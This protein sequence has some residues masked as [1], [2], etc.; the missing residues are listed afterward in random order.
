M[1]RETT[2]AT[3]AGLAAT[4]TRAEINTAAMKR[5]NGRVRSVLAALGS[6]FHMY[7][8]GIGYKDVSGRVCL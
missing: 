3:A 6:C 4:K 2:A 5:P 1:V 7:Q 8:D